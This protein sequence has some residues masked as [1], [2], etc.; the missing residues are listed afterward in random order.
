[1]KLKQPDAATDSRP[2]RNRE[3]RFYVET[4]LLVG[5][6]DQQIYSQ[7]ASK[8]NKFRGQEKDAKGKIEAGV[9]VPHHKVV[10]VLDMFHKAGF[11]TI[12]FVGLAVNKDIASGVKWWNKIRKKLG[13]I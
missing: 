2:I 12:T 4:E 3:T 5:K 1:M 13:D 11:K 8:I 6:T 9:G 7:I 10:S